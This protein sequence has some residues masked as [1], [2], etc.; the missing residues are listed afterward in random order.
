[1]SA[2]MEPPVMDQN[3]PE[4]KRMIAKLDATGDTKLIWDPS[5]A[6]EVDSARAMF[7]D[8][9]KKGYSAY[10]VDRK[11]EKG[12]VITKFDPDV[13]KIILAPPTV[14]G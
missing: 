5:K 4:G 10:A 7:N 12:E 13:E 2:V 6:V 9:K 8:L 11:G 3:P 1:M 14:G